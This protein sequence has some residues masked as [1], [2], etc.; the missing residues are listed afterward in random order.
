MII[1]IHKRAAINEFIT[2]SVALYKED[3]WRWRYE[4]DEYEEDEY[5]NPLD[6][7]VQKYNLEN[8]YELK[9]FFFLSLGVYLANIDDEFSSSEKN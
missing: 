2:D 3:K 8:I 9:Y 4:D 5:L 7:Y 1:L 6:T